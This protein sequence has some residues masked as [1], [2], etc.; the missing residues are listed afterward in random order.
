MKPCLSL[1][2][3]GLFLIVTTILFSCTRPSSNEATV[4]FDLPATYWINQGLL[5]QNQSNFVSNILNIS[6]NPSPINISSTGPVT[7]FAPS[8]IWDDVIPT[9]YQRG[10][11]D[12]NCLFI[13]ATGPELERFA[14][15]KNNVAAP[16]FR[17]GEISNPQLVGSQ[18]SLSVTPGSGRIFLLLGMHASSP[19]DCKAFKDPTFNRGNLSKPY[20]IGKTD[21][22]TVEAGAD[23]KFSLTAISGIDQNEY[24]DYCDAA[25]VPGIYSPPTTLTVGKIE[26]SFDKELTK[27]VSYNAQCV[28]VTTRVKDSTGLVNME[29]PYIDD[30]GLEAVSGIDFNVYLTLSDCLN[31]TNLRFGFSTLK[32]FETT[33]WIRSSTNDLDGQSIRFRGMLGDS[34]NVSRVGPV[35]TLENLKVTI[36]E[37]ASVVNVPTAKTAITKAP[38]RILNDICYQATLSANNGEFSIPGFFTAPSASTTLAYTDA[39]LAGQ[40]TFYVDTDC[41]TGASQTATYGPYALDQSFVNVWFKATGYGAGDEITLLNY[42][43]ENPVVVRTRMTVVG[44]GTEPSRFKLS[45]PK[46]LTNPT[47]SSCYGPY[48]VEKVNSQGASLFEPTNANAILPRDYNIRINFDNTSTT[49]LFARGGTGSVA[50]CSGTEIR[51]GDQATMLYTNGYFEFYVRILGYTTDASSLNRYINVTDISASTNGDYL[52]SANQL[53]QIFSNGVSANDNAIPPP[54]VCKGPRFQPEACTIP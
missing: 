36:T 18:V 22:V 4:T 33:V 8:P 3:R 46:Y 49:Q 19:E 1:L 35:A 13:V 16:V 29:S 7:N 31:S 53:L 10:P 47:A 5:Q 37:P 52:P 54:P 12:N 51:N 44:G 20:I 30:F 34:I 39:N 48:R 11:Y 40:L 42:Y 27:N 50:A 9:G 45:G 28:P 24:I 15:Y 17:V 25:E 14:C 38:D 6:Q 43:S 21:S 23:N 41:T 32:K 2:V 26:L